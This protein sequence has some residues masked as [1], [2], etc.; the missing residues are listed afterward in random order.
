MATSP[1]APAPA[2]VT[3]GCGKIC[4]PRLVASANWLGVIR[5]N[6]G[7]PGTAPGTANGNVIGRWA[8][9]TTSAREIATRGGAATAAPAAGGAEMATNCPDTVLRSGGSAADIGA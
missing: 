7:A 8:A 2:A 4:G 9:A 6:G 3:V 1:G 5:A